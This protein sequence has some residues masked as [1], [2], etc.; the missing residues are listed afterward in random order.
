M[1]NLPALYTLAQEFRD[2]AEQLADLDLPDEVI[3]DTL[4]GARFPVE[5]KSLAVAAV[6]GNMRAHADMVKA[7]A[8]RKVDEAKALAS[9]A[10]HLEA[11]LLANMQACGISEIAAQDGSLTITCKPG[12]EKV[13]IVGQVPFKYMRQPPVPEVE[14]DKVKIRD[15][16]KAGEQL[17]FARLT[18]DME[19]KI[20]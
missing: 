13:K 20:K 3:A 19:V 10:D 2:A 4:E 14:P 12:S 18:R 15:A 16:L 17:E 11:Y 6:I 7:F 5:Q 9:R 1:S 8:K